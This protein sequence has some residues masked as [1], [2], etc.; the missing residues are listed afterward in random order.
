[1]NKLAFPPGLILVFA[2]TASLF[3]AACG[4][5]TIS[6]QTSLAPGE[7]KIDPLL[8]EYYFDLGGPDLLG[9]PISALFK[10]EGSFCQYTVN[11]LLCQNPLQTGQERYFFWPISAEMNLGGIEADNPP[12]GSFTIYPDFSALHQKMDIALGA[13]LGE[14]VYNYTDQRIEQYFE[15]AGLYHKFDDD[16]GV[17][18]LLP[19]GKFACGEKCNNYKARAGDEFKN[20]NDHNDAGSSF[21]KVVQRLGGEAVF[22]RPLTDPYQTTDGETEQIYENV[23]FFA[24]SDNPT[25]VRIRPITHLLDMYILPPGSPDPNKG[26][27]IFF[28][29][30]GGLGYHVPLVFDQ[31]IARHGSY[32]LSGV[33][34]A[35]PIYYSEESVIRQCFEKY[36]LD[37]YPDAAPGLKV[38]LAPLGLRYLNM[39]Q[40]AVINNN[41]VQ[42]ETGEIDLIIS[43][44]RPEISPYESQR[45]YI[46]TLKKGSQEG[47][48][49][50]DVTVT[51]YP[52]MAPTPYHSPPTDQKGWTKIDIPP[53]PELAN[54][55][56]VPYEVC[57]NTLM[58]EPNC[59]T[60]S[61]L[62]WSPQ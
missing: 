42:V 31:F 22:G 8:Y 23:V 32:E 15:G 16:A 7:Y 34:V 41:A 56:I 1:M 5:D 6:A 2:M 25:L 52:N 37:Y 46:V 20:L 28:E 4:S 47:V 21:A 26:N 40:P 49:D 11:V 51:L 17:A 60:D 58:T 14:P 9:P 27:V 39:L 29:T 61:Y 12:A 50:I 35:D 54:G 13:P 33:P 30:G 36:C 24:T 53:T 57:L 19:L 62:I 48:A 55:T 18:R 43:E 59:K 38:R 44:A 10:N 3:L 45:I